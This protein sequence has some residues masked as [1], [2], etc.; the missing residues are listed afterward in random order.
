MIAKFTAIIMLIVACL[1]AVVGVISWSAAA[2]DVKQL[3]KD[4]I[5]ERAR[6]GTAKLDRLREYAEGQPRHPDIDIPIDEH[7]SVIAL[8][9][10]RQASIEQGRAA[11]TALILAAPALLIAAG[12]G[13][14]AQRKK[15][16][17]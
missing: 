10:R 11:Q 2:A 1:L 7:S 15:P 12:F 8:R 14:A 5:I 4:L 13:A 3:Q 17:P 9:S 6:V 16:L